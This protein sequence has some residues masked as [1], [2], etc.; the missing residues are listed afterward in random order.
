MSATFINSGNI[1]AQ[2][3]KSGETAQGDKSALYNGHVRG[4]QDV[5][6]LYRATP[7]VNKQNAT[8]TFVDDDDGSSL[9]PAQN[10]TG[11][12]DTQ[13]TFDN[14][15]STVSSILGQGYT[16]VQTTGN[17]VTGGNTGSFSGVTFPAYD[18]DDNT[19]QSF[20]VHFKKAA[21]TVSYTYGEPETA[22]VHRTINY[23]DKV[24]G[25]KIP[26]DLIAQNPVTDEVTFTRTPVLE[27]GVKVGYG[28][29]NT[30]GTGYTKQDWHTA[31]GEVG[32]TQFA[33]KRSNDL[34][35]YNYTAPEFKDGKSAS[36]V[37][38][39]TV[40]PTTKDIV[41][42]VYYGHQTQD[43]TTNK[44]VTRKFHYV[45][46]DGTNPSDHLTP[47]ADQTVNFTGT[48]T[49]DL[50]TG[51][52]GP[53]TWTPS[54]GTL[55]YVGP[56]T[57]NGYTITGHVNANA[58]GS[59]S[60]VNVDPT[61]SDIDVTLVYTPNAKPVETKQKAV[62]EIIDKTA[63]KSLT[64]FN[65]NEG[66]KGDAISFNGEPLTL[67]TLLNSGYVFDSAVDANGSSIGASADNVNFGNFDSIDDNVQSFKIYLIHGT[68]TTTENA[69]TNAHVHYVI[70]GN[71]A[72]KPAAPADSATQTINWTKTNTTDLVNGNVTEG[73]WTPDKTS[74]TSVTSPTVTD[75]T[76]DQAVANF[77][78]PQPNRDQ[79]VTVVYTK[80]PEAAQKADLII[81]D[82]TDNNKQLN[83][84][85][86]SGKTGTQ[87][88]F[89]GAQGYVADLIVRGY[90]IDSFVN[91]QN[92]TS[93]LAAY[94][95]ITFDNFDNNSAT[96]QH[97]KLYLVHDTENV[98]D[99]KTT[100]STVHYV[101]SDGK[102][103]PPADNTQTIDWTRPGTKDKVTGTVTPTGNWTTTGNYSNV[104]TPNL[105]GYTPDK[106]NVPAPTPNPD[107]NPSTVVTYN[108][109]TPEA[110]TY[111]GTTETKNVTRTINYYDSVTGQKIPSDLANTNT[112]TVTLN[113][114][115]VVSSTG[116]DMGYGTVSADGKIFTK[117]TTA[118]GWNT[119]DWTLVTSPD[120]TN[121]G[122]TAPDKASVADQTVTSSTKDQNVDVYY[123]HQTV[124]VTPNNPQNPGSHINPND[125]RNT[126]STYPDGLTQSDLQQQVTRTINYVGVNTDGLTV[127]VNG[128]PDGQNTY[129]QAVT[130]ERHAVVDK[131]TGKILGYSTDN[132][133]NVSTTDASRAWLPA[134]QSM[135]EVASKTPAEVGYDN[136]DIKTVGSVTVY[137]GQKIANVTVT[138]T[139]NKTPEVA[140]NADLKIIDRNNPQSQVVLS[141]YSLT[142]KPGTQI[143]FDGSQTA[144]DGYIKAGYKFDGTSGNMTGDAVK[145]FTY[146]ALDNDA[147]S[148]QHFVI[149]LTHAIEDKTETANANA[150]VHYIVADNGA[151]APADSATQTITWTRTNTVDKTN[152]Q[153]VKEGT[154][155]PDKSSFAN[156]DSPTLKGYTPSQATVQFAT[157][158]R[159]ENQIVN[160]VYN[161]NQA[162][163]ANLH[164]IDISDGN[165]NL[166]DF[167]ASGD[168]NTVINFNGAQATIDAYVKAGYKVNGIVQA[169]SD[170]N[171][172]T[173]Y[174][175]D[176]ASAS[177]Q[178]SF[179]DKPGVDQ[180]FY[181]Y[182]KH[183][184][185]PI[186]PTNAFGRNDLTREVTETVHYVDEATG[187]PVATDYTNKVTFTGQGM[188]DKVT[189]K[190]LK[191]K[192]VAN[193]Q[194]TYDYNVDN[195]IDIATAKASD[196]AWSNPT[197]FAKATSPVIGGYT[198]DAAKTTPSDLADGNDIKE[199]ANVGYDHA[200][201]EATVY[202]KA[203]P[204]EVHKAE[205]TIYANGK[206]VGTASATGAKDTAI[207]FGNADQIVNSYT[208]NGYTFDHAQNLNTN[209]E[210][211][212]K[213]YSA[214]DFGNYSTENNSNQK[215]A[216]YLTKAAEPTQQTAQLIIN[217]VTPGQEMQLGSY[218]QPGLEGSAISFDGASAQVADLLAKG[219]VWDSSTYNGNSLDAKGYSDINF[220]N[221]DNTDDKSGISQKWVINLVH[222]YTPV[223]PGQ[224]DD[225]DGYTK[226]YLDKTITRD[227]TYVDEQGNTVAKAEHQETN[228]KGSGYLDN[229]TNRW[230]TV[231]NGKITGTAS[232]LTWTPDE[233]QTFNAIGA[234]TVDGYHVVSVSGNGISGFT[235]GQDG[236]VGQQTVGRNTPSSTIKVVY[237]KTV[238]PVV[239]GNA[240]LKI[241]DRYNPQAETTLATFNMNN[242]KTGTQI[243]FDNSQEILNNFLGQ[244]YKYS[245]VSG[246]MTGDVMRGF[247][248]PTITKDAQHFVIYL[249]HATKDQTETR[250]AN[251]H[252]HYIIADGGVQAP[253][254][255]ATQTITWTRTNTV[256]QVTGKTT[257][258]GNW[259]QNKD[260]FDDVQ[261]PTVKGYT[262]AVANVQFTTPVQGQN[263]VVNVVYTKNAEIP[264]AANGSI[265]YIDDVT[266][267]QLE[268]A[269]FGGTV[270]QKINYTTQDRITNYINQGYKLVS[271]NFT[272]GNEFYKQSG[273]DFEVHFTHATRPV[274]P[275]NSVDPTHPVDP[276]HPTNPNNK[277]DIPGLGTTDL[278]NT[279]TRTVEYQY[280]DGSQAQSPV[281]QN[282]KFT[283]KGTIDL[284][285]GQLVTVDQDGN[286]TS[287]NG[288]ITWNAESHNFDNI[289][290]ISH[291]GYYISGISKSN[292]DA[293]VDQS[294]GAVTGERVTPTSQNSTIVITLTKT[295]EV[296]VN[297]NGSI[298]YID[299]TT[300][301]TIEQS[302]FG[303][304]VG[305][306]INY[307]T[308]G[309]I[310]SWIKKGYQLVSNNFHDG[311][312]TFTKTGN[313]FEV[314][315]THATKTQ[316]ETKN[317]TRTVTYVYEDGS[318]ASA[319]VTQHVEFNGTGTIDLVTGGYVT[320]DNNGKITGQGKMVWTPETN[321][322]SATK[323]ID[324][325]NY[326]IVRVST[327]NTSAN[328][329]EATGV[330]DA[331][332]VTP[333]S[334]N[335]AVVIT[336]AKKEVT[337]TPTPDKQT[338]T[339]KYIDDD[340]SNP[341]DLSQYNKTITDVAGS[342]L[343]YST[344]SSITDL[345]NKGYKLVSDTFTSANLGGKMPDKG[346]NYEVHFI[347]VTVPVTPDKPGDPTKPINPND[348]NGPKWP[349][350]STKANLTKDSTQTITYHYS[351]GSKPDSTRVV[352]DKGTFTKTIVVDKVTGKIVSDTPWVGSHTFSSETVPVVNGYHSDKRAV[353]G[354]TTTVDNPN[355]TDVV[356]YSP[357]G[358]IIPVDPSGKQIP[359]VP[360][361][362]YPT[363]PTKVT[364]NEPVPNVPN[365][366]PSQNT[367]TP[368]DPGKDTP[369]IYNNGNT[370][371]NPDTPTPQPE[372]TP[373]NPTTPT[374]PTTPDE[375]TNVTPH[376]ETPETPSEPEQPSDDNDTVKPHA[377]VVPT[378]EK[379]STTTTKTVAP[380]AQSGV[381]IT[382]NGNIINSKGH[383]IGYVDDK[384]QVHKT[385]PQTGDSAELAETEAIL[386][387][388]AAGLGLIG[389][390]G[391][392]KRRRN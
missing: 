107:Q 119:G 19:T 340:Q 144:L 302:N 100:T 269:N 180:S 388:I 211:S 226:E 348:P 242:A 299:D 145:G 349:E 329:N 293:N 150:H 216:I 277:R 309:S 305:R 21:P 7:T 391:S 241:V 291:E 51:T 325:N 212:G 104:P 47:Q 159:G 182:L 215:F 197:T 319:P 163:K 324:M 46:T 153:T 224:P 248:Y 135:S 310:D 200:N 296:P 139:K 318:Q 137:P 101:V 337:P 225:K 49:K 24:T 158:V 246:N 221:Y 36:V 250:T 240:D 128:A 253:A 372:V 96:D 354:K 30:D 392:K 317:V 257:N 154:W 374:T 196:F 303:G 322:F 311:N 85:D 368:S 103:N 347:H 8:I 33:A 389:L 344:Q 261:S 206:Q 66:N 94:S 76:P 210:M 227:V 23:Y 68:K 38:A 312:E 338:V 295:P 147:S 122:Y 184:Y 222:G 326:R 172:P 72:N 28:T 301:D 245:G 117:A 14:A 271:S 120:L 342:N 79:V 175:T 356:T 376:A 375:P 173:K 386:G 385:L 359:N 81:Y 133:T 98:T 74:F 160:V 306:K 54:T 155:T 279:V 178:W 92:Q 148:D 142:D 48:A 249:T 343:N 31:D 208:N 174:G 189:G 40:T 112:Q 91:D 67:Q 308:A 34:S 50:V 280:S 333:A 373:T 35:A 229:V 243:S 361:P 99:K 371:V 18:S 162:E 136:V 268:S 130:F 11:N 194:I 350:G 78:T 26:S 203:N 83:S 187:K 93:N 378:S 214:L 2:S 105:D 289:G 314:H 328:V 134:T 339:V 384:G 126:P 217:D 45:F 251:A 390:A 237:A 369:V 353:G 115:H 55:A 316:A 264:V 116:Q 43:V 276:E 179:D 357:N 63:N 183:D 86:N 22:T 379:K 281:V 42:N 265:K 80:N 252:V 176:Y 149:Y 60:A 213:S 207:N 345:E 125:P 15:A 262:P 95:D 108:P 355:V 156:V 87:I 191:V 382:K 56:Q 52:T 275:T 6:F 362:T 124:V 258:E 75:Y 239:Y 10:A 114:T 53:T 65:N 64:S 230:V 363:D 220:G 57:V 193:G 131:V 70:A 143:N 106:I 157:P 307:T 164:I 218:A 39:D 219:Y 331:E 102:T 170:P 364:P 110:P 323:S 272:D 13:I 37:P 330:V 195:E 186:N 387:G 71:D 113:R 298:K 58:D 73:N 29:I 204:V 177:S 166:G 315:F 32:S 118:D 61:S 132:T 367:V 300:N 165:K 167:N 366:V 27:N 25:A 202:Y 127:A 256:D 121:A 290:G 263:Q 16:Y 288:K 336:L 228:F 274:T 62:V 209:T 254:D 321:N 283:G 12:A 235:V 201:V 90:K 284:V 236:S 59:A 286:I 335:S 351:D 360:T 260:S 198:I 352:T 84:F 334:Q 181:V 332:T 152:G 140:Q 41:Y 278:E 161:K 247:V 234:K 370:P 233:D 168:D 238:A 327:S 1:S 273:N 270:G 44:G 223:N 129:T 3:L 341:Q 20:I 381:R 232:G 285:T 313:T 377:G 267:G 17:G 346:G 77:T 383:T 231:E 4:N 244:G 69:T 266:G 141:N 88:S 138:Y 185:T 282:F 169:T 205:L 5:V 292:T 294:T 9:S 192:S 287:Q 89:S 109:K 255:S 380:H 304:E 190:M 365:M 259:M 111:T 151:T 297:V 82:K 358:K 188:V 123:G 97:F 320:V 199:I 146:P 171:N